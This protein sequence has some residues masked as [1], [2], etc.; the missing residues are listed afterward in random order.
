MWKGRDFSK[1][2]NILTPALRNSRGIVSSLSA[3][4]SSYLRGAALEASVS[5][6]DAT[7]FISARSYAANVDSDQNVSALYGS[8][9][10]RTVNEVQKRGAL[11]EKLLGTSISAAISSSHHVG[12]TFYRAD[13]SAPLSLGGGVRFSGTGYTLAAIDYDGLYRGVSVFAEGVMA[14]KTFAGI[15]GVALL[16]SGGFSLAIV[17]RAYPPSFYSAHGSGFGDRSDNFNE[18]GMYLGMQAVFDRITFSGY[19]DHT[20]VPMQEVIHFPS[21]GNELYGGARVKVTEDV[22]AELQYRRSSKASQP[23]LEEGSDVEGID[24]RTR[25]QRL[26]LQW[27][28]R[29][30]PGGELRIRCERS[31]FQDPSLTSPDKGLLVYGDFAMRLSRIVWGNLRLVLFKT[32]SYATR[33]AEYE[34]DLGG[35]AA[36]PSLYGSGIRWYLMLRFTPLRH[37]RLNFKYADL[38]RD[39]VRSIGAGLEALT[40]NHDDR[41]S[42]EIEITF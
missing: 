19:V 4:E 23:S 26:R 17:A 16:P 27:E 15:G 1:G 20:L 25:L 9:Y 7:I 24:G 18:Y 32:D 22:T 33:I 5:G 10:Y 36:I 12:F 38:I 40:T 6:I 28:C 21:A 41:L 35:V 13:F 8:G 29:F 31:F 34:R 37:V 2:G 42:G 11:A 39:D 30:A 14:G 3:D